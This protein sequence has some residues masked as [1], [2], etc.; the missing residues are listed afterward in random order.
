M[1]AVTVKAELLD[2]LDEVLDVAEVSLFTVSE[3]ISVWVGVG[4][5]GVASIPV[6]I[7]I[8]ESRSATV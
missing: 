5:P 4:S 3:G 7:A 6:N 2:E 8:T 1:T